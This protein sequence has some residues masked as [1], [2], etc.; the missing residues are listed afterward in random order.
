MTAFRRKCE[1][2]L[3][4]RNKIS[5]QSVTVDICIGVCFLELFKKLVG[6]FSAFLAQK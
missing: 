2:I 5:T 3:I 6:L 1:W 4:E